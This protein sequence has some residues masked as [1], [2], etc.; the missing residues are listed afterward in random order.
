MIKAKRKMVTKKRYHIAPILALIIV[1]IIALAIISPKAAAI[2]VLAGVLFAAITLVSRSQGEKSDFNSVQPSPE[3]DSNGRLVELG[4]D[5]QLKRDC[6]NAL[7]SCGPG[8]CDGPRSA[9][10]VIEKAAIAVAD[11]GE[12]REGFASTYSFLPGQRP[13]YAVATPPAAFGQISQKFTQNSEA[14]KDTEFSGYKG[15]IDGADFDIDSAGG[16]VFTGSEDLNGEVPPDSPDMS[17]D[18]AWFRGH[19]DRLED[20]YEEFPEGNPYQLSRTAAPKMAEPC[21]DD[22]ANDDQYDIDE[23]NTYQARARN[24][25]TRVEAGIFNRRV[26]LDPYLREEVEEREDIPWWGRHEV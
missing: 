21:I 3:I 10:A 9:G 12:G 8:V 22:E 13:P 17:A 7:A 25:A 2:G 6:E 11:G 23:R 16:P 18:D 1:V 14:K 4:F 5:E 24:D 20:M 19:R 15:A 26:F